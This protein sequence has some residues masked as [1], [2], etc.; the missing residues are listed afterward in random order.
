SST[1]RYISTWARYLPTNPPDN[2]RILERVWNA[3]EL[4]DYIKSKAFGIVNERLLSIMQS[5]PELVEMPLPHV[6]ITMTNPITLSAIASS[7][8]E[9]SLCCEYLSSH[10]TAMFYLARLTSA[11]GFIL[12]DAVETLVSESVFGLVEQVTKYELAV[13][14]LIPMTLPP[15]MAFI[16]RH[17]VYFIAH[18][19]TAMDVLVY[20]QDPGNSSHIKLTFFPL[21]QVT[22]LSLLQIVPPGD[23]LLS[24]EVLL[25]VLFNPRVLDKLLNHNTN[26]ITVVKR[27]LEPLYLQCFVKSD[28]DLKQSQSLWNHDGR[29]IRSL[30]MDYRGITGQPLFNWLFHPIELLFKSKLTY[31]EESGALIAA[32]SVAHCT[33][34]FVYSL[35]QT[36]DGI[37]F[38]LIYMAALKVLSLEGERE[39]LDNSSED[40]DDHAPDDQEEVEE[41]EEDGFMD[42]EVESMI[43]KLLDHFSTRGD[44]SLVRDDSQGQSILS[45][46]VLSLLTAPLPFSQFMKNFMENSFTTGALLRYQPTASRLLFP[47]MAISSELQLLIWQ[48]SFNFLGSITT[49]WE[50][51]DSG[52]LRSLITDDLGHVTTEVLKHYLKAVVSGRV[53]KQR[54]PMLYWIAVHHL[55]RVAFGPIQMPL[56]PRGGS[57]P[58]I[59]SP[60]ENLNQD[61]NVDVDVSVEVAAV[62]EERR[63][64]AKA[65]ITGT[66]SEELIRDWIQYDGRNY[67][68]SPSAASAPSKSLAALSGA[69]PTSIRNLSSS[70]SAPV[71]VDTTDADANANKFG[72]LTS[73]MVKSPSR[74]LSLLSTSASFP[75]IGSSDYLNY[76]NILTPPECFRERRQL[77]I[78]AR[79]T[80]IKSVVDESGLA[81]VEAAIQTTAPVA[82]T[83]HGSGCTKPGSIYG[84]SRNPIKMAR[85]TSFSA[86]LFASFAFAL[87]I[88]ASQAQA[89]NV[90]KPECQPLHGLYKAWVAPCTKD[91]TAVP[92]SDADPAWKP[93]ICKDGFFHLAVASESCAIANTARTRLITDVGLD[94]LCKDFK[95]YVPAATQKPLPDLA[96]ALATVTSISNAP[97][98][99]TDTAGSDSDASG[100]AAGMTSPSS[101]NLLMV[102]A[103]FVA[104]VL[105]TSAAF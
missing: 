28:Q 22:A 75:V 34:G 62:T 15:W 105:A 64:I 90:T 25:K 70:I 3:L 41:D 101:Q 13:Q 23:E 104:V 86:L 92:S 93:C 10:L 67:E 74:P 20:Q 2:E 26:Q 59:E 14:D 71:I 7:L 88:F 48:E 103:S 21:F 38:E 1:T 65:I 40:E 18:W 31:V 39:P 27:I 6:G 102:V 87:A 66:N 78:G 56:P 8:F 32:T 95:G 4:K 68:Q 49:S 16:S 9:M 91:G 37:S 83:M 24:H 47:A 17:G 73:S 58:Q 61:G 69:S 29:G 79:K 76:D 99:P 80:W 85:T 55:A 54:N 44:C 11:P 43:N 42:P 94:N 97:A 19:L 96:P 51:L 12:Q 84:G 35:L 33:L 50:G 89:Q 82:Q 46:K 77:M 45:E 81:R 30:V 53:V 72:S 5:V 98:A 52:T 36:L 63:A 57:R 100:S 60:Q